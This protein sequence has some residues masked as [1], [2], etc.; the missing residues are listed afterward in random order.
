MKSEHL[1]DNCQLGK[2]SRLH[3]SSSRYLNTTILE[4]HLCDLWGSTPI[5]S[6]GKI[7]YYAC[8]VDDLSK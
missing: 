6:F 3:F 8:L 4:K 7:S 5:L 2:L 1:Y